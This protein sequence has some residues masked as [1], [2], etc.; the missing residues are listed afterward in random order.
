MNTCPPFEKLSQSLHQGPN[1]ALQKHL[2]QCSECQSLI[3]DLEAI[4]QASKA[5]PYVP[6][7]SEQKSLR[8]ESLMHAIAASKAQKGA[9]NYR[10]PALAAAAAALV[11]FVGAWWLG[12]KVRTSPSI[13]PPL[14]AQI[15]DSQKAFFSHYLSPANSSKYPANTEILELKEGQLRL[16]IPENAARPLLVQSGESQIELSKGEILLTAQQGQL[17]QLKIVAGMATLSQQ[18]QAPLKLGQGARWQ[19]S[20]SEA[21]EQIHPAELGFSAGMTALQNQDFRRAAQQLSAAMKASPD[22]ALAQD[23]AYWLAVAQGRAGNKQEAITSLQQ[24]L[25]DYPQAERRDE[26]KVMLGWLLLEKGQIKAAKA[27]FKQGLQAGSPEIRD[28]AQRGLSQS[29]S[30]SP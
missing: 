15:L 21:A 24:Y 7:S 4:Q 23:I 1:E 16:S 29:Y 2:E 27:L 18:G 3:A 19:D 5:L 25:A 26:V 13:V 20:S 17:K 9:A 8:E 14:Q 28:S 30:N 12:P 6:A 22:P 11:A 10:W